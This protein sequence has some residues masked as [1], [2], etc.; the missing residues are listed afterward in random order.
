VTASIRPSL[1]SEQTQPIPSAA[2][3]GEGSASG[4]LLALIGG[5]FIL[6]GILLAIAAWV[7]SK[8]G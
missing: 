3:A 5:L 4:F 1:T 6:G 2:P 7:R 8:R